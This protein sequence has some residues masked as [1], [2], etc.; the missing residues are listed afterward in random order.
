MEAAA[1]KA[2]GSLGLMIITAINQG[3]LTSLPGRA[4]SCRLYLVGNPV[5]ASGI[6]DIDPH[7]ALY[8]PFRVALYEAETP[9]DARMSFDRPSLSLALLGHPKLDE[10]GLLLDGKIDAVVRAVCGTA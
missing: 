4:K 1:A 6:F 5:I 3:V 8:V 2:G 7:A 9:G 10:I